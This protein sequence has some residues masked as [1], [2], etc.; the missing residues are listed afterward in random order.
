MILNAIKKIKK[1]LYY[2][3]NKKKFY[4]L[5]KNV[6]IDKPLLIN[7]KQNISIGDN[8][9]FRANARIETVNS[10]NGIKMQ[11][12]LDIGQN[13]S[14]EQ[15]LHLICGSSVEIGSDCVFS[16]RVYISDVN[17][18]YCDISKS[19]MRQPLIC[20]N[21]KI[22]DG[23]FVG[24]NTSILP[25]VILGNHCVVGANSVVTHSF[26]DYSVICGSPAICIKR[27]DEILNIWRITDK[28]GNYKD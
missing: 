11:P 6:A 1:K 27:Y 21:V 13:C 12:F 24:I 4:M 5:G 2:W 16:A 22:G 3:F 15:D 28:D 25:G 19:V 9:W 20:K 26:P 23:C 17:H 18:E 10:W 14:F 8:T 7:E